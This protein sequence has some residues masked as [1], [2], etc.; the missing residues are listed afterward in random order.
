MKRLATLGLTL[1]LAACD[2]TTTPPPVNK[3]VSLPQP[4]NG[5]QLATDSVP[6]PSGQEWQACYFFKAPDL[7]NGQPY[8]V[9]KIE[10]AQNVGSHHMN[11]FRQ[12]TVL[13]PDA[14]NTNVGLHGPNPDGTGAVTSTDGKGACF[15]SANWADWP[16]VVNSQIP[17]L[18]DKGNTAPY[19]LDLSA[20]VK[21]DNVAYKFTPGEILMLQSHFVN[22]STQTTPGNAKAVANFYQLM[23]TANVQ[24]VATLFATKQSIHICKEDTSPTYSGFCKIN[25]GASPITI[26][27]ANGHFHSRGR[28]FKIATW[29]GASVDPTQG[30]QFYESTTW[31]EP[32]MMTGLNVTPPP[33]GGVSWTCSY[34][35]Q[36]SPAC[37]DGCSCIKP[38]K[39]PVPNETCCYGFGGV[40]ETSEHCNAFVYYY[41]KVDHTA[42]ICQ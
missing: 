3:D 41:P 26:I 2:S 36:P 20:N 39:I 40:V 1:A 31:N 32:P 18:D 21:K 7:N 23:N 28:D 8:Y 37:A 11:I 15:Y 24:E 25:G 27:A 35:W 22:A 33:A 9:N 19:V 38:P 4:T 12:G 5:F 16:L 14:T 42:I 13:P 29:D 17:S 34:E 6:I 10:M 30:T